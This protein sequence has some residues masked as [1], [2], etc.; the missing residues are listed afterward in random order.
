[1][2]LQYNRL[3][4]HPIINKNSPRQQVFNLQICNQVSL[5]VSQYKVQMVTMFHVSEFQHVH[6]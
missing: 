1:M 4:H 2:C 6:V 3:F 5:S